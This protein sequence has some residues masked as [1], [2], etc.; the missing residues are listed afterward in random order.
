MNNQL[1]EKRDGKMAPVWC[2]GSPAARGGGT[3][4]NQMNVLRRTKRGVLFSQHER[5]GFTS[6][7]HNVLLAAGEQRF[8]HHLS[9]KT[10]Q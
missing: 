4:I 3:F 9:P 7:L 8:D 2:A 6:R 5:P 10:R 1:T